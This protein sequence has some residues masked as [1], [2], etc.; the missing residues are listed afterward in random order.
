[1]PFQN[2]SSITVDDDTSVRDL[3][4]LLAARR[5]RGERPTAWIYRLSPTLLAELED[6]T[7]QD[8]RA[9]IETRAGGTSSYALA[10]SGTENVLR[11]ISPSALGP[12]LAAAQVRR[13][14]HFELRRLAY[15]ARPD[16]FYRKS[17]QHHYIAPSGAHCESFFRLGD[18]VQSKEA[19]DTLA[20]W[21]LPSVAGADVVLLDSWSIAAVLLRAFGMLGRPPPRFDCL[22]VHPAHKPEHPSEVIRKLAS[23]TPPQRLLFL[24]SVASSGAAIT[25]VSTACAE[26]HV[27]N[28]TYAAFYAL[29]PAPDRVASFCVLDESPKNFPAGCCPMCADGSIP[30]RVHPTLF[31]AR[32]VHEQE[33]MLRP[34]YFGVDVPPAPQL[35]KKAAARIE[36]L[37]PNIILNTVDAL[38]GLATPANTETFG[39]RYSAEALFSVHHVDQRGRHHAFRVDVSP[40][41][42]VRAF[43]DRLRAVL[44]GLPRAD[45]IVAQ[46]DAVSVEL[47]ESVRKHWDNNVP[48]E[49][50]PNAN[51]AEQTERPKHIVLVDDQVV[52]GERIQERV[53]DLREVARWSALERVDVIVGLARPPGPSR[54]A[55][56]KRG[57]ETTASWRVGV[58]AVEEFFLPDWDENDCPWCHEFRLF[59]RA[60]EALGAASELDA[61]AQ[62]LAERERGIRADP[63]W[64]TSGF[65]C[66]SLA[67]HSFVGA[68]GLS[69]IHTLFAVVAAVERLRHDESRPLDPF[70]PTFRV[71]ARRVLEMY[72]EALLQA[73]LLRAVRP[74]EWGTQNRTRFALQVAHQFSKPDRKAFIGEIVLAVYRGA[75][76]PAV[77]PPLDAL[78]S[79]GFPLASPRLLAVMPR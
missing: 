77:L 49:R 68:T 29:T 45:L 27:P 48:M 37:T 58:H 75:I 28:C 65:T 39:R 15:E 10:F 8:A 56:I 31:V 60:T 16:A 44:S 34:S 4:Q 35:S 79:E 74:S 70:F 18:V 5:K 71:L 51:N 19:L 1:M 21:A 14:A 40:I 66:P 43:E 46:D 33:V 13:L 12:P 25:A 32:D 72:S 64:L 67:R 3:A 47:A 78:I 36:Q 23:P 53:R 54:W 42:R 20:F 24:S 57:I 9:E 50:F 61:R 62:R 76:D 22:A 59:R 52:S 73:A 26:H 30:V 63:F 11:R 69:P 7:A 55:E 17:L 6:P 41:L 2:P 38:A